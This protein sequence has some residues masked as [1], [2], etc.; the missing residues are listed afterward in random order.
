MFITLNKVS[1]KY[2]FGCFQTLITSHVQKHEKNRF[3]RLDEKC[4]VKFTDERK[5]YHSE[6]ALWRPV[7]GGV[8]NSSSNWKSSSSLSSPLCPDLP[9]SSGL[10]LGGCLTLRLTCWMLIDLLD[11]ERKSVSMMVLQRWRRSSIIVIVIFCNWFV[12]FFLVLVFF[13]FLIFF[14]IFLF[15]VFVCS[16][17]HL[18]PYFVGGRFNITVNLCHLRV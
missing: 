4:W 16:R 10:S 17:T 15:F 13:C 3:H 5:T 9:R 18:F 11:E 14:I 12:V 1:C 7:G 2:R 8:S 6:N